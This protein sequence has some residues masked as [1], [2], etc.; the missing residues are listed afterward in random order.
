MR[1]APTVWELSRIH[2]AAH[3]G[4]QKGVDEDCDYVSE[5]QRFREEADA[6]LRFN[7][8]KEAVL[9][10]KRVAESDLIS[11]ITTTTKTLHLTYKCNTSN[12]SYM[13]RN[14]HMLE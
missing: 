5:R 13:Y 7:A 8:H 6:L 3:I 12:D 4:Q 2:R 9:S 10:T 11:S 14:Y 1:A